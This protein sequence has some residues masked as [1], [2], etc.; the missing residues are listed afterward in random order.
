MKPIMVDVEIEDTTLSMEV[1]TGCGVSIVS[2]SVYEK[3]FKQKVKV[4]K[5]DIKLKTF[6][7]QTIPVMGKCMVNVN[8]H[9]KKER[10][11]LIIVKNEGPTLLGRDWLWEI[12]LRWKEIFEVHHVTPSGTPQDRIEKAIADS[13]VFDS[14]VGRIKGVQAKLKVKSDAEPRFFKP[15]PIPFAIKD[16]VAEE[17]DRLVK[18]GVL[19]PVEFSDWAAP[20]STG[21]ET[22][23]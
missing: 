10:L 2:Q 9:G 12:P 4:D 13:E 5:C 15:R 1:D 19:E 23:W 14:S 11:P 21:T 20:V 7:R 16:K 18:E 22:R 6:T 17:I 8:Y 3:N